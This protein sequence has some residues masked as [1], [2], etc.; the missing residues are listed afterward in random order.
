MTDLP[1]ALIEKA[2]R[3][4]LKFT[5]GDDEPHPVHFMP[6]ADAMRRARAVVE[7]VAP[8]V[9]AQELRD[10][11]DSFPIP[12]RVEWLRTRALEIEFARSD[13]DD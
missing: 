8:Q 11:A 5:H 3:A 4:L 10:A 7:A 6:Q 12:S 2:A 9:R 13:F 1:D